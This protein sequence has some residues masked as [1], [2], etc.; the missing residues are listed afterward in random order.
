MA[1]LAKQYS[2]KQ[3]KEEKH[4]LVG[5]SLAG[6]E[7]K[8]PS[9]LRPH[10]PSVS[11][12]SR[13][14]CAVKSPRCLLARASSTGA[15]APNPKSLPRLLVSHTSKPGEVRDCPPSP[16]NGAP[17]PRAG[18]RACSSVRA[19]GKR[20]RV[21]F[22]RAFHR[23]YSSNGAGGEAAGFFNVLV[24]LRMSVFCLAAVTGKKKGK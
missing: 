23:H 13:L 18:E 4:I 2:S 24:L 21:L 12:S 20:D 10:T 16:P 8:Y 17:G 11:K 1:Q 9:M 3:S 19:Q 14:F 6:N 5:G 22:V 15:A 7:W